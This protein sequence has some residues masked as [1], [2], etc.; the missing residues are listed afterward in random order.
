MCE[1]LQ[2]EFVLGAFVSV[3]GD[4]LFDPNSGTREG[5]GCEVRELE[6]WISD[7]GASRHMTSSPDSMTN[8]RECSEIVTTGCTPD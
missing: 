1:W 7:E 5:I 2:S 8:Y 4:K 6:S 3:S